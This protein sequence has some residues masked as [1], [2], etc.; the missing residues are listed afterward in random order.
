MAWAVG[1]ETERVQSKYFL[2]IGHFR[3]AYVQSFSYH[4]VGKAYNDRGDGKCIP[5]ESVPIKLVTTEDD[6]TDILDSQLFVSIDEP[7]HHD[8]FD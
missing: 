8:H 1:E 7:K 3:V 4:P 5:P 6:A 2:R